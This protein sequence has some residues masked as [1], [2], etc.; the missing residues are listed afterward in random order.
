M[1][2]APW[3]VVI[4]TVLPVI[5]RGYV[6]VVRALGHEPVAVIAPRRR[7]PG[8][9]PTPFAAEHVAEA[10]E[11]LDVLFA[12]SKHSLAP[13]L[14]AYEPDLAL[15]TGF[16]WL[17]PAEAIAVPALG[18]VNGHPSLL[19]RYRGPFPIAWAV[20]NGETE[21][22]MSYH[23]MDAQFDTG[24][25]LAQQPIP[26]AEDETEETL[27]ARFPALTWE[28]LSIVFDRLARGDRGDP[29]EGGEYQGAFEDDYRFVDLTQTA[30][31]VHRQTRAW[32]FVPPILPSMGPIFERD[33]TRVRLLRTS[34]SEVAGAERIDCADA[35]LWILESEPA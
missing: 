7:A 4:I 11:E 14:R 24:N 25:V 30:E 26:L 32:S 9:P 8:A 28:L 23:L 31:E 27:F 35:P 18:I 21:I 29:Q 22:G 34:L 16:P 15:C 10:P 17:I 6:E 33:G 5:A 19:P 20:R 3:R 2:S 12:S 13:L 1:S